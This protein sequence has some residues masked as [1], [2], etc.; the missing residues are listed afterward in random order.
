MQKIS[1]KAL[2]GDFVYLHFSGH[3]SRQPAKKGDA[4]ETDGLDEL[5]LPS[6]IGAWDDAVGEVKNALV[7]DEIGNSIAAI[8]AKGAFVW[9]VFD[10]CHSGTVTRGAPAGEDVKMRKVPASALGIPQQALDDAER[11]RV[12][13]RGHAKPESALGAVDGDNKQGGFVAFYAAQTT[14]QTPEM[15]LPAGEE[16]RVPHGLFSFTILHVISE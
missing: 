9:A 14:E 7:D 15:R 5:F 6:D 4:G 16:G 1:K 12:K 2:A 10:S 11:D 13:T 8:R 3:G